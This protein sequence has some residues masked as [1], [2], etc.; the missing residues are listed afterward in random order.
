MTQ[1]Q[2]GLKSLK[3]VGSLYIP[4]FR[5]RAL[6]LLLIYFRERESFSHQPH[7]G[8]HPSSAEIQGKSHH[9]K[10]SMSLWDLQQLSWFSYFSSLTIFYLRTSKSKVTYL[11]SRSKVFIY[12]HILPLQRFRGLERTTWTLIGSRTRIEYSK[13]SLRKWLTSTFSSYFSIEKSLL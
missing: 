10:R 11:F 3:P 12:V 8:F 5:V 2:A 13:Y 6:I 9:Y 4:F 7:R 1:V